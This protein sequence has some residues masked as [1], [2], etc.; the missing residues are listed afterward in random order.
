MRPRC[1]RQAPCHKFKQ[2]FYINRHNSAQSA[3]VHRARVGGDARR[4]QLVHWAAAGHARGRLSGAIAGKNL[5]G[6]AGG[7]ARLGQLNL[8]GAGLGGLGGRLH[9]HLPHE[10]ARG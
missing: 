6:N 3:S 1:V 9:L 2:P 5:L 10:A 4:R 7:A 8:A